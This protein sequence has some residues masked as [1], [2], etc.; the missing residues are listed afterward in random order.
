MAIST[1]Q[2]YLMKGTGSGSS[3]TYTKLICI[4]SFPDMY[5]DPE[6]IDVTTLCDK[7]RHYIPGVQDPGGGMEFGAN[8]DAAKFA[9]LQAL[10]G[11]DT[12]YAL[13]FGANDKDEPDGHNGKFSW[14][15][16]LNVKLNGGGVNEAV[17]MTMTI[18]PSSDIQFSAQ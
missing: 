13:W 5:G 3:I 2:T 10:S 12:P 7:M 4:T 9:E 6:T 16:D 8:Y 14:N 1:Y 15:G 11:V 18:M 17:T